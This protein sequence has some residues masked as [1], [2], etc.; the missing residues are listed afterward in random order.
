M[1]YPPHFYPSS[2]VFCND[3][4]LSLLCG[5]SIKKIQLDQVVEA[6]RVLFFDENGVHSGCTD[7]HSVC[8]PPI[9]MSHNNSP[10]SH[11]SPFPCASWHCPVWHNTNEGLYIPSAAAGGPASEK[12]LL[13]NAAFL[14]VSILMNAKEGLDIPCAAA[15]VPAAHQSKPCCAGF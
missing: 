6:F 10:E 13:R 1:F 2:P 4:M 9:S 7:T 11:I 14:C 3:F 15:G 8:L 12:A 5:F